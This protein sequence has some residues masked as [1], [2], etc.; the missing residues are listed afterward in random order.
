LATARGGGLWRF[1]RGADEE[2]ELVALGSAG[3][4]SRGATAPNAIPLLIKS[5]IRLGDRDAAAAV[6][7][8]RVAP[9]VP[10][11]DLAEPLRGCGGDPP[12]EGGS[13]PLP[14]L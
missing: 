13:E 3:I 6:V 2:E 7:P 8:V 5:D 9:L 4:D 12:R 1:S 11:N 10:V 14:T